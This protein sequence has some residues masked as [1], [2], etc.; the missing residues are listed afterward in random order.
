MFRKPD[1]RL[2]GGKRRSP[3]RLSLVAC[4]LLG[5]CAVESRAILY[6]STQWTADSGLPQNSVRGIVQTPDGYL[7]VA[8]LN[9]VARFDGIR[10]TVFDKSNTPGISS[11]RFR[12]M[13]GGDGGDLWLASEDN[14]VVR[15]HRGRFETMAQN[16][17]VRPRTVSAI[18]NDGRGGIWIASDG[19]VFRWRPTL[20]R[21][22]PETFNTGETSFIPLWWVST[23]F[24]SMRG[25]DLLCFSHGRLSSRPLPTS[26]T[27]AMIRGVAVDD[28]GAVWIGLR[29]RTVGRIDGSGFVP[30]KAPVSET[31]A[32]PELRDWKVQIA[33]DL[34]RRLFFPSTGEE[35][36]ILYNVVVRDN[37]HNLWAGS[38]GQGLFR[39][40]RQSI[41]TLTTAQGLASDNV[42]PI[43]S[44]HSG[45][46]WIGSWPAGLTRIHNNEITRF[47]AEQGLPGLVSSLA[48]DRQGVLWVGTHNGVRVLRGNRLVMPPGKPEG[49]LPAIQAIYSARDGS[50]FLGTPNGLYVLDGSS[51]R[52]VTTREGLATDDVRVIVEDHNEDLWIGGYGGLTRRH[53]GTLTRWTEAQGLPSN[54]VRSVMED[55]DG[56]IWVGTYD[57]GIGWLKDGH[58]VVFNADRGLFDN[59][60][61]DIQEDAM[62]RLWIT[63]N[64]GIYRVDK[65]QLRDVASGHAARIQSIAYG[66]A[67]GMLSV[68]CNGGLWPAGAKD[69]RGR[70]WFPTQKGVAIVYPASLTKL[71]QPPEVKIESASVD[72]HRRD[73][74]KP[75]TL[76]PGESGLEIG[77]TALS[78]TKPEQIAFRYQLQGLDDTWVDAGDRRTA[79][80]SH[81][82]Q[83]SYTFRV[84]ATNGD[85][86]TSVTDATLQIVVIPPFYRRWWFLGLIVAVCL[87]A[88]WLLWF[89]RI[90]RLQADQ[91]AQQA[92]SRKLIASQENERRRI[93]AELHDS[94]GQRLIVINN[95]AL[96]LLKPRAKPLG[97]EDQAETIREINSEATQAMDE[98]R[99]ISYALRPFQLDR[100]G[101]S[102]AIRSLVRTVALASGIEFSVDIAEIDEVFPEDARINFFRII[103]EALNNIVK[104]SGASNATVAVKHTESLLVLTIDDNGRG[105]PSEARRMHAGPGGFGLSG[106]RERATLLGGTLQV[107]S[108]PG[109]GTLLLGT[110][111]LQVMKHEP[112]NRNSAGR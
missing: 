10:F 68:E 107:K 24:W 69:L 14:N 74:G 98:T 66:R 21:F 110:F 39:I 12:E 109:H 105:L 31:F 58:W 64:R 34:E 72:N 47:M 51:S 108:E 76:D 81:L 83:G 92:F 77:Y 1:D 22:E 20:D 9:G 35:R 87:A 44:D 61:F 13:V 18:T 63:S 97:Q 104:H 73:S 19:V 62:H 38:E 67:D 43:L 99:A 79:Y 6:R 78:Y 36:E 57:G 16:N 91:A 52:L 56:D 71:Q 96:I 42:Y 93:A 46:L 94:L 15:Y 5:L 95:L 85:G 102:K 88:L 4:F 40:Q 86:V 45:D 101:L 60:A 29:N 41:E 26:L 65:K 82:P 84:S 75:I 70:L 17:G 80:Y 32:D 50:M 106:I 111:P 2:S 55:S 28:N 27:A 30:Q 103:Q 25:R 7:W 59:G 49:K 90:R 3:L 54:N 112:D 23:G 37:E 89:H 33:P 100:L 11:N 53:A 8:T 48:E